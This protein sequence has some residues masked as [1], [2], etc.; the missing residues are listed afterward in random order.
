MK[1]EHINKLVEE[2][3]QQILDDEIEV[4]TDVFNGLTTYEKLKVLIAL[5]E[6][7]ERGK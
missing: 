2:M 1:T 6:H 7:E 3:L 4:F 5:L